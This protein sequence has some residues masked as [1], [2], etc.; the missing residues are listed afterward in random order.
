[1][2]RG[3]N[4]AL[5]VRCVFVGMRGGD[6]LDGNL[7]G[8]WMPTFWGI[9]VHSG[10]RG[11]TASEGVGKGRVSCTASLGRVGWGCW[12]SSAQPQLWG[13]DCGQGLEGRSGLQGFGLYSRIEVLE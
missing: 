3:G 5:T 10:R 7:A 11:M 2:T 13:I 4:L 8:R 12:L 9:V 6:T 1:M